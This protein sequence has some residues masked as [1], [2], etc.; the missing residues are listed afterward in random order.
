MKQVLRI[1]AFLLMCS[2]FVSGCKLNEKPDGTSSLQNPSSSEAVENVTSDRYEHTI[3][4]YK[5]YKYT[6]FGKEANGYVGYI[7]LPEGNYLFIPF[8]STMKDM[9]ATVQWKTQKLA[10]IDI[11]DISYTLDLQNL[12]LYENSNPSINLFEKEELE[13]I[14]DFY[15]VL[16]KEILIDTFIFARITSDYTQVIDYDKQKLLILRK[17]DKLPWL[18]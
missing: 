7:E 18:E 3:G 10:Q 15:C 4:M 2:I 11:F 16:D 9:G 14:P 5:K 12:I 13:D 6:V 8:I 1:I 17:D